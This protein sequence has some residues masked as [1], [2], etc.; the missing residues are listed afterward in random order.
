VDDLVRLEHVG[1]HT[2]RR[3]RDDGSLGEEIRFDVDEAG[4][5]ARLWRHS[6]FSPRIP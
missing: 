2:F 4:R 5:A 1:S 3:I 6:N